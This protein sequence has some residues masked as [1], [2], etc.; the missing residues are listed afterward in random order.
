MFGVMV[1]IILVIWSRESYLIKEYCLYTL[2]LLEELIILLIFIFLLGGHL[3]KLEFKKLETRPTHDTFSKE[4]NG[5]LSRTIESSNFEDDKLRFLLHREIIIKCLNGGGGEA[6]SKEIKILE[7][8]I[9][10]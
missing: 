3:E 4:F 7:C 10:L 1:F 2:L 8:F 9:I 5:L 6:I